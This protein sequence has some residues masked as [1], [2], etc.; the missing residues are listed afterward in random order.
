MKK[1][2]KESQVKGEAFERLAKAAGFKW[3]QLA[4]E[5]SVTPQT[6]QNWRER[7]VASTFA[8]RA[9]ELLNCDPTE[10]SAVAQ[11][12]LDITDSSRRIT[13]SQ[14]QA[15]QN[16]QAIWQAKKKALGLTQEEAAFRMGWNSQGAVGAYLLGRIALNTN[17]V[18]KFAELLEV[19]PEQIDAEFPYGVMAHPPGNAMEEWEAAQEEA[20]IPRHIRDLVDAILKRARDGS[21]TKEHTAVLKSSLELMTGGSK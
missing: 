12:V 18:L 6:V 19:S 2:S 9:A 7:G 8:V 16:L 14:K 21:L 13:P 11:S 17:A 10:I 1:R 15:Q 20:E 5:L 4:R 3:A